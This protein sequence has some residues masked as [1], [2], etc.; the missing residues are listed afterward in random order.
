MLALPFISSFIMMRATEYNR[1]A[2]ATAN[3][4]SWSFAQIIG[5]SGGGWIAEKFGFFWLW[6][7]LI[8]LCLIT[9]LG[10]YSVHKKQKEQS[11]I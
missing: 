6:A 5:P 8:A 10:F 3:T 4:L 2:Y 11:I 9:G 7:A 1:G